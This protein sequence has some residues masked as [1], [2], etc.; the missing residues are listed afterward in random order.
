M[1]K[2]N[3]IEEACAGEALKSVYTRLIASCL[4]EIGITDE[5]DHNFVVELLPH[6]EYLSK[7]KKTE[8][9][10]LVAGKYRLAKFLIL[11]DELSNNMDAEEK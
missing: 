11:M 10:V 9:G 6:W 3:K 7:T 1:K 5:V 4:E 8:V 2:D